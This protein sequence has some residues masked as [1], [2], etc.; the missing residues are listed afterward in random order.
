MVCTHLIRPV[1]GLARCPLSP[2]FLKKNGEAAPA[3]ACPATEGAEG[4]E[5]LGLKVRRLWG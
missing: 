5:A 2:A 4:T 1:D 3:A